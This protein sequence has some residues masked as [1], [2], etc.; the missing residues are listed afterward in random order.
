M[1]D[2]VFGPY[3]NKYT[4]WPKGHLQKYIPT[5]IDRYVWVGGRVV[6]YKVETVVEQYTI[7]YWVYSQKA[8]GWTFASMENSVIALF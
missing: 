8:D 6:Y 2:R 1:S 3:Q 5:K 7:R 4:E